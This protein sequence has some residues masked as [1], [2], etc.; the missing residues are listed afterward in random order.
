MN[1][2]PY[3]AFDG[4]CREAFNFYADLLGGEIQTLITI[5]DMPMEGVSAEEW[6]DRILH[7]S[8]A[9]HGNVI[10]GGDTPPG[11]SVTP[12]GT[13][14]YVGADSPAE[15]ERIYHALADG[16]RVDMPVGPTPWSTMFGM[17]TDRYGTPWIIDSGPQS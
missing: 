5:K 6:G 4:T 14:V 9:A 10:M 16:G 1:I 15:V 3:L 8:M 11:V 12:T 17:V 2:N 7:A 13:C